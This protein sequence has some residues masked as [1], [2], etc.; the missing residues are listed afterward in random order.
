MINRLLYENSEFK[1]GR[2]AVVDGD[3][4]ATYSELINLIN[5]LSCFL[6]EAGIKKGDRVCLYLPNSAEFVAGFFAITNAGAVCVPVNAKYKPLEL[7]HYITYSDAEFI[8][9]SA[10]LLGAV[11]ECKADVKTIIIKG[12]GAGWDIRSN[13][14][15][16]YGPHADI[17][18][19][20]KAI[21]LFSTGSTGIPKCVAR[22]HANLLA[23]AEN[24]T[25]TV[26]WDSSDKILFVIPVSHTYAFGNLV[27]AL[28]IGAVVFML[29][30]FNR[31]K[32]VDTILENKITIFPAVPFMIDVLSGYSSAKG[33]D[34]SSLKHVISAGAPLGEPAAKEFYNNFNIYPRQLYGSSE[35]G[36]ISIN[37]AGDIEERLLSVGRPV[38][39]VEVKIVDDNDKVLGINQPGEIIVKSPSMTDRYENLPDESAQVFKGGYYYTGD[40]G[41]ID[42]DRYIYITG[43]KKLFINVSGQKVDP[44]EVEGVILLNEDVSEVAVVGRKNSSGAEY[45]A[46]YIVSR[47]E[48]KASDIAGFCRGKI[49]DIK[50]PAKITFVDE[51]PKSPTGKV[52]RDKLK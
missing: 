13:T 38:N 22:S 40:I 17:K 18:E 37:L 20:D 34:F 24:H 51:I 43:R 7:K 29:E 3:F 5:S 48:L 21:Y 28:K 47:K 42:P 32:V 33:G 23:L 45:V 36:V 50:I 8:I 12:E 9:T 6:A 16:E 1:E 25:S 39:N 31:K 35:T 27:S 2:T 26:G 52:L 11:K 41:K 49:S 14:N 19:E 30:D 4:K 46:A 15:E 10:D 44:A